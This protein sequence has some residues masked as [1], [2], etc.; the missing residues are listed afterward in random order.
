MTSHASRWISAPGEVFEFIWGI[1]TTSGRYEVMTSSEV[2]CNV[3]KNLVLR[4]SCRTP[5]GFYVL[6]ATLEVPSEALLHPQELK[7]IGGPN[8]RKVG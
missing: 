4:G 3:S 1:I 5:S 6:L 8:E 7:I 2:A